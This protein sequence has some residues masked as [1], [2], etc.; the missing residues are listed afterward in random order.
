M[1]SSD[2]FNYLKKHVDDGEMSI[3]KLELVTGTDLIPLHEFVAQNHTYLWKKWLS[4]RG[5]SPLPIT[6]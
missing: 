6:R 2:S 1:E 3:K 4:C 5:N